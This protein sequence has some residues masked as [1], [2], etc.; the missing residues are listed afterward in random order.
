[1]L[2]DAVYPLGGGSKI[3]NLEIV[4]SLRSLARHAANLGNIYVIGEQPA[5]LNWGGRLIHLPF[6]ETHGRYAN[7]WEKVLAAAKDPR[8][9][10]RFLW[11]NDDF[12]CLENFDAGAVP[13]FCRT[14]KLSSS[15][16]RSS[17]QQT[18]RKT[19]DA[20]VKRGL[21]TYHFGTHQPINFEKAK[22]R[23]LFKEFE[24]EIY[25]PRGLSLRTCYGNYF[26]V[27]RTVKTT[28]LI[29]GDHP[30]TLRGLFAVSSHATAT[31]ANLRRH[32]KR[33]YPGPSEFELPK[34]G[35][36]YGYPTEINNHQSRPAA[37]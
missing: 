8:I 12:Y 22:I 16:A 20:L 1:M 33:L 27:E 13:Y 21:S 37:G 5:R 2:F 29:K 6:T 7:V 10:E 19:R 25:A 3:S 32:I 36:D 23:Q 11:M 17:Y 15:E 31:P 26:Q 18:L 34:K 9:S 24:D 30:P 28:K 4:L 14:N 35:E